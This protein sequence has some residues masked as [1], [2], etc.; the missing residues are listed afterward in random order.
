MNTDQ[1]T[2]FREWD[3]LGKNIWINISLKGTKISNGKLNE[4]LQENFFILL[5][6]FY[7]GKI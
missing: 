6:K 4:I 1:E 7:Y 2:F 3:Q 5:E